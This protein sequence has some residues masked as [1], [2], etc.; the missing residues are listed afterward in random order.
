[1]A[2]PTKARKAPKAPKAAKT[3]RKPSAGTGVKSATLPEEL[4]PENRIHVEATGALWV[5]TGT[6]YISKVENEGLANQL[7]ALMEQRQQLALELTRLLM[8]NNF[9]AK[10]GSVTGHGGGGGN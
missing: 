9:P 5:A 8:E 4:P 10:G 7:K 3:T 2:K 1:M 6:G